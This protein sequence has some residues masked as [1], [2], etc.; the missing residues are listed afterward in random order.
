MKKS[1]VILFI[2]VLACYS[3]CVG[4]SAEDGSNFVLFLKDL[5][6]SISTNIER[7]YKNMPSFSLKKY[8]YDST[9][10]YLKTLDYPKFVSTPIDSFYNKKLAEYDVTVQFNDS[11]FQNKNF[12]KYGEIYVIEK[13]RTVISKR[14]KLE[15]FRDNFYIPK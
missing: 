4:Q 12:S 15:Y 6:R 7:E 10:V 1:L 3:V 14:K 2:N 13:D 8:T 11:D 5:R 9:H